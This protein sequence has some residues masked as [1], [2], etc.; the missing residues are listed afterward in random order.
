M[1]K[2]KEQIRAKVDELK[3]KLKRLRVGAAS[4]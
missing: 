4:G 2:T 3:A 1:A